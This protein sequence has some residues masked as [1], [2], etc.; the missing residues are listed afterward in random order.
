M[1][2]PKN[3]KDVVDIILVVFFTYKTYHSIK[4]TGAITIFTGVLAFV[5]LWILVSQILQMHFMGSILDKFIN[6]GVILLTIVFQKEIREFLQNLG[7]NRGIKILVKLFKP[8]SVQNDIS[9]IKS[10]AGALANLAKRKE[11]ALIAIQQDILLSSFIKTGENIDANI[12]T[13]LIEN[14]FFKNSPLH[15]GAIIIAGE[16]IISA[17]CILPVSQNQDI[18]SSYG[19]RHRS[20]LGLSEQT[21]AKIIIISEET[22]K[23][24][25]AHKGHL[26]TDI[27]TEELQE[28]LIRVSN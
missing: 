17:A 15:D 22:G 20:A 6:V 3:I 27:S 13:L 4:K 9:Y 24:S 18:P 2:N 11:G 19:L 12:N 7:S 14:I 21:D 5:I 1:I 8:S 10:I 28:M 23:I 16:R 26:Y 25:L